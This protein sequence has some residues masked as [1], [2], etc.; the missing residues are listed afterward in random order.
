MLD[1]DADLGRRAWVPCPH[2]SK[3][4]CPRCA[5][6]ITCDLHWQYLLANEARL[7]FL[8]CPDCLHRW[9][10]DTEGRTQGH[11]PDFPPHWGEAA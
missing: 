4:N 5:E 11:P 8:Q 9:W 7:V 1:A 10:Y 6:G 2:C 3:N